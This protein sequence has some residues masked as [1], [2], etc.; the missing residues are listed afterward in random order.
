MRK[1]KRLIISIMLV[2]IFGTGM[3]ITSTFNTVD[4]QADKHE[5]SN[6]ADMQVPSI[7]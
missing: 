1:I 4:V 6:C 2:F 3:N 7:L 5:K